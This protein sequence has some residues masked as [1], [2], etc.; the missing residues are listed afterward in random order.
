MWY[1][2]TKRRAYVSVYFEDAKSHGRKKGDVT[3]AFDA[4]DELYD[5]IRTLGSAQIKGIAG[6]SSY[7]DLLEA[8]E[9]DH[10]SLGNYIKHRLRAHLEHEEESTSG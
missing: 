7:R 2:V 4:D 8:A 6:I 10:R 9:R 1:G 3:L 5:R